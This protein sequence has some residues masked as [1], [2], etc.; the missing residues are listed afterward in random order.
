MP[1]I[2][3]SNTNSIYKYLA[4]IS[5]TFK[6]DS[7]PTII[8]NIRFKYVITDY[9][10]DEFNYPLIYCYVNVPIEVQ[11]KLASNQKT[12]TLVFT[13]QKYIENSD[14][15]GLKVDVINEECI[16]F[17]SADAGKYDEA[18][19]T[20]DENKTE[21]LGAN[22][23]IGL[24]ALDHINKNKRSVNAVISNGTMSSTLYYILQD[25]TLL[26][27][28]LENNT[29]ISNLALPPIN[30]VSKTIKYL[31]NYS[32]FYNTPYRFFMDFDTTY[33]MSSSG[34]GVKR[35]G[36]KCNDFKIIVRSTYDESNMEG[37]VYDSESNMYIIECSGTYSILNDTTDSSRAFSEIGGVESL[38]SLNKESTGLLESDSPIKSKTNMI[39][40][41][42]GNS[43]L[44]KNMS[45]EAA[46]NAVSLTVTKNKIDTTT[47]TPNRH[48]TVDVSEVYN[49][50]YT[51]EYLLSRKREIYMQEGEGMALSTIISMKRIANQ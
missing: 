31:N 35:R 28:S 6:G 48:F 30:S 17:V 44:I 8:E 40:V 4:Q 51:G 49:D 15:P 1:N 7:T 3:T 22:M 23:I 43:A 41:T 21:D 5:V 38:G 33:L 12:G 19:N 20:I 24:I 42:N 29:A 18:T 10:Y 50:K 45:V 14:M 46:N 34:K 26:I 25:H 16:Y 32:A 2:S 13:L 36:E 27:E 39:R 47:I 9:N 37:M 11:R